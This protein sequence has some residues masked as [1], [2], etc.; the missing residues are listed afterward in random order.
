M[1]AAGTGSQRA[2]VRSRLAVD[3][4]DE[5]AARLRAEAL[6]VLAALGELTPHDRGLV[7]R[8]RLATAP[9]GPVLE[10]LEDGEEPE[11]RVQVLGGRAGAC[12]S[13]GDLPG[14]FGLLDEAA[15][16]ARAAGAPA[17]ALHVEAARARAFLASGEHER[18]EAQ[19]MTVAA[20][21]LDEDLADVAIDCR[22][23][24]ALVMAQRGRELEAIELAESTLGITPRDGVVPRRQ[25]AYRTEQRLKLLDL[26]SRLSSSMEESDRAEALAREAVEL[27]TGPDG[28]TALACHAL[29]RLAGLRESTDAV[30]ATRLYAEALDAA[31]AS[32]QDAAAL[33][34][35]ARPHLGPVRRRRARRGARGPPGRAQR[36]RGGARPRPRRPVVR[37]RPGRLGLP[38]GGRHPPHA[39]PHSCW[40]TRAS[41]SARSTPS[42]GCPPRGRRSATAPGRSTARACA[43]SRCS[44]IG[45]DVEGLALLD[46]VAVRARAA[47]AT[48]VSNHAAS[49]A[50]MW[51]DQAGRPEE[52]Q[53]FWERHFG[54]DEPSV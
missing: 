25:R 53:A 12:A 32:G 3:A 54:D 16:V 45:R 50:A 52:A 33:V 20:A 47:G 21:A 46:D 8:L 26:A 24:V 37:G 36:Q 42:T 14:A 5:L 51:L 23:F 22:T 4:P 27:A 2:L 35:A 38:V 49:A 13:S 40:S 48:Q 29:H 34:V 1:D 28:S 17:L 18:A 39:C 43:A 10:S 30:E 19:A 31:L 11:V 41:T 7:A 9:D 15:A 6:D 44:S